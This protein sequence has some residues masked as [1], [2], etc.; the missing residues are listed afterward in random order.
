ML[1]RAVLLA[2]VWLAGCR[3]LPDPESPGAQVFAQR[4]GECHRAYQPG[5][6]TW[7]M[8]EYQM[9]RMKLLFGQLRKPW[10]TLEEERLVT[11]YLQRHAEGTS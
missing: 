7:P 3:S 4:C 2:A 9:G 6:M 8:W 11:E 5:S 10:L 1:S